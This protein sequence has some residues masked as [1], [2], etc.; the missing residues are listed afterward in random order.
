MINNNS[1]VNKRGAVIKSGIIFNKPS[2]L[3][4]KEKMINK[5]ISQKLIVRNI[6]NP[7]LFLLSINIFVCPINHS[8]NM[9]IL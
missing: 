6:I 2:K 8:K 1:E 4:A 9:T 7:S 3:R 5:I